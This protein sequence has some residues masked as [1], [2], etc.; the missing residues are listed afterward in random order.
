MKSPAPSPISDQAAG[1]P[2]WSHPKLQA[3]LSRNAR[4]SLQLGIIED[5]IDDPEHEYDTD[6]DYASAV[7]D[8]V[9]AFVK[10]SRSTAPTTGSAPTPIGYISQMDIDDLNAYARIAVLT[11]A[12]SENHN[13]PLY[14][15]APASPA[16]SVPEAEWITTLRRELMMSKTTH[17]FTF[18]RDEVIEMLGGQFA[19][20]AASMGGDKS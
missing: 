11:K 5:L 2:D 18:S 4:M 9:H 7:T 1:E 19:L 8:K 15:A 6:G 3:L 12:A 20:L 16:A 10:A 14:L 17:N 13:I